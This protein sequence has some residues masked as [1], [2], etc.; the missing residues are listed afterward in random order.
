MRTGYKPFS[1]GAS[2]AL[3]MPGFKV[4]SQLDLRRADT[5]PPALNVLLPS[6]TN[7]P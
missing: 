3:Q 4:I 2:S 1:N 6:G 7:E 5:A